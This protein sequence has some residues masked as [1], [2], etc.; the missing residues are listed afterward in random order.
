VEVPKALAPSDVEGGGYAPT[1]FKVRSNHQHSTLGDLKRQ[2]RHEA[3]LAAAY[4]NLEDG[5]LGA[6]P[7]MLARAEPTF[8]LGIAQVRVALNMGPRVI[9]KSGYFLVGHVFSVQSLPRIS[10]CSKTTPASLRAP[11]TAS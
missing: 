1:N 7:E 8:N 11:I 10:D 5:V 3:C 4:R 6:V 2:Q 9:E